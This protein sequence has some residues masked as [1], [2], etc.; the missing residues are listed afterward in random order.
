MSSSVVELQPDIMARCGHSDWVFRDHPGEDATRNEQPLRSQPGEVDRWTVT[1]PMWVPAA[2]RS[3]SID[4]SLSSTRAQPSESLDTEEL[5]TLLPGSVSA[6][7]ERIQS[8]LDDDIRDARDTDE[9]APSKA[10]C[11]ACIR[12]ARCVACKVVLTMDLKSAAFTEDDGAVSLG[13]Q[14]LITKRRVDF[15]IAVT[16]TSV[17]ATQ[18]DESMQIRSYRFSTDNLEETRRLSGWV[19]RPV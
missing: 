4:Q 3:N 15:L 19:T 5:D 11:D 9:P 6:F 7:V 1:T 12:L 13:I 16:G 17:I 2:G 14:S 18:I 10:A 8:D